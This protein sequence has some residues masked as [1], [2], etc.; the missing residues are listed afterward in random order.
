MYKKVSQQ[1][2]FCYLSFLRCHQRVAKDSYKWVSYKKGFDCWWVVVD[3]GG[4]IL[5]GGWWW[6]VMDMFWLVVS[7]GGWWWIYFGW[8]CVVAYCSLTLFS[9][10]TKNLNCE[11]LIKNL[12]TFKR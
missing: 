5:G 3:V 4:Y 6:V 1:L 12:V 8:W 11:I 7:G 9:A 2:Q 10:I